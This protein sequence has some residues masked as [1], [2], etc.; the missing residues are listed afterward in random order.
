MKSKKFCSAAI[1]LPKSSLRHAG[2]WVTFHALMVSFRENMYARLEPSF[3]L[4]VDLG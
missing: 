4:I 2:S 1:T 3:L